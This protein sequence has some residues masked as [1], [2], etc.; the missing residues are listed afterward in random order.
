[1]NDNRKKVVEYKKPFNVNIGIIIFGITFLYIV[2][3]IFVF[4][5]KEKTTFY[6]V[7]KG[8]SAQATN[9]SY[10]GIAIFDEKIT[11]AETS[12]Y[13]NYYVR[14]GTRI[15]S[16]S[17]LYS[18]D[19]TGAVSDFLAEY[20]SD[21]IKLSKQDLNT[22]KNQLYTFSNNFDEMN[23]DVVYDF[24]SSIEGTVIEL[25]NST[26]LSK[27]YESIGQDA[28]SNAFKIEK[29]SSPGIVYYSIDNYENFDISNISESDFDKTLYTKASFS[30][31]DLIES[32]SPI[33]KTINDEEWSIIIPLTKAEKKQY[34]DTTTVKI[35]F[36]KDG[37]TT[38]ADFSIVKGSD[39]KYGKITLNKYLIRYASERYIDIQIIDDNISGLKIPKSAV[40]TN[41]FYI[42]PI[43]YAT[44]GADDTSLGFYK[45]VYKN[46]ELSTEF[47]MPTIFY[48]DDE[49]YYIDMDDFSSED[50]FIK[51]D[52][53]ENYQLGATASL[54]GVYNIN[55][56]YTEFVQVNILTETN[57]YYIVESQTQY[58]L[59]IYDHI[60]MDAS[61]VKNH[62]VIFQ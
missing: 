28:D 62:Q 38:T 12:G 50:I 20:S 35:K 13:I 33:C 61:T 26:M 29:A 30:S 55:S 57:E 42:V 17:T 7:V 56:G 44:Y 3:N 48:S 9:Y 8:Q 10:Q 41:D 60:I 2:I 25:L 51:P 5:A 14:E 40:T 27:I 32:G 37:I 18:I 24:K 4:L 59:V 6:E 54:L 23:F 49:Y 52:S 16:N 34:K 11:Y 15:S 43:E 47:I 58:G 39:G 31:G 36:L 45:Q 53:T 1:M 22:I 46:G 21:D 19:E